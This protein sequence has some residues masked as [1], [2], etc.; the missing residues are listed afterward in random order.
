[1][2]DKYPKLPFS[3]NGLNLEFMVKETCCHNDQ[4]TVGRHIRSHM[5]VNIAEERHLSQLETLIIGD[6][7]LQEI[8]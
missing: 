6:N 4:Y 8:R 1:M 2:K 5:S 7:R 3:S